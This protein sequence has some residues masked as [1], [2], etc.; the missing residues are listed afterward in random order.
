MDLESLE[1]KVNQII[2][3]CF[4]AINDS[5]GH[6]IREVRFNASIR[7]KLVLLSIAQRLEAWGVT[8]SGIGN[9][10]DLEREIARNKSLLWSEEQAIKD[11]DKT[12]PLEIRL[13]L[14]E[15]ER[16]LRAEDGRGAGVSRGNAEAV[17]RG[18]E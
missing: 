4:G 3:A 6:S 11:L 18:R 7:R 17:G 1:L 2:A 5:Q 12:A 14:A 8:I 15:L 9:K 16:Y 10:E 13:R